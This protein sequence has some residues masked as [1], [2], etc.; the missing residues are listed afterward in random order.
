MRSR[1]QS[2]KEKEKVK[3]GTLFVSLVYFMI[4]AVVA[5]F[6]SRFVLQQVDPYELLGLYGTQIPLIKAP[7]TDIPR[8]VFHLILGL[9]FF[10]L[11]Q[12]FVVIFTGLLGGG[13]KEEEYRR[14]FQN[15]WDH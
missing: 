11:L 15:P 8:W 3:A 14:P 4:I 2:K 13:K 10:F 12:P 7:A 1:Q 6:L 5:Y 9:I